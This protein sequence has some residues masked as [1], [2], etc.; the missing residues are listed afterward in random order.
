MMESVPGFKIQIIKCAFFGSDTNFGEVPVT[1]LALETLEFSLTT[2]NAAFC[3]KQC[4]E[5]KIM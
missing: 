1:V 4:I 3:Y 5:V 2:K